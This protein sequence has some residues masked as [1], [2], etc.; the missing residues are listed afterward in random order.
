MYTKKFVRLPEALSDTSTP[1][2]GRPWVEGVFVVIARLL[3]WGALFVL[4][5]II[6]DVV[7]DGWP[8]LTLQFFSSFPSRKAEQ[9]GILAGLTGS[10]FLMVL[11]VAISLPMGVGAA[12]YLE[13]YGR[14]GIVARVIE[15]CIANLAGVPSV[16]FGLLGLCVFAR[17]AG[18][19]RSLIAGAC[20][21]SLLVLPVIIMA[22]REALRSVPKGYREGSLALGATKWQTTWFQ[23]LPVALPGILTGCILAFSRAIG[24]TA[25]LLA[26]GALAYV[27]AIPESPLSP[28]TAIPIQAYNWISRPQEAFHSNAAAALTVLIVLMLCMNACAVWGRVRF[29]R[30]QR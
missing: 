14:K 8:R 22:S 3:I 19:G 5:A 28:F 13:E 4:A 17:M 25:P 12:V 29:Q 6:I 7:S 27:A 1:L 18:M 2:L 26:L 24:E 15:L 30:R 9:A 23:V 11:T 21:L 20:T 10:L 16:I